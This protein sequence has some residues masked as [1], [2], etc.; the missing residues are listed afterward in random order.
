V[1]ALVARRFIESLLYE[2]SPLDPAVYAA[3]LALFVGAAVAAA[4][5]PARRAARVDAVEMLREN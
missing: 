5:A 1:G 3:V 2:V 4:L